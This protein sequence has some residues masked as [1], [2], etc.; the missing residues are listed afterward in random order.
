MHSI[1]KTRQ[2]LIEELEAA[3]KRIRHLEK[4]ISEPLNPDT[5]SQAWLDHSPVST[6]ALDLEFKLKYMSPS[7]ANELGIK[8]ISGYIGKKYPFD[9][10]QGSFKSIMSDALIKVKETAEIRMLEESV[11]GL[12]GKR[13]WYQ[14]TLFPVKDTKG[15]PDYYMLICLNTN[16][17]KRMEEALGKRLDLL[18]RPLDDPEV[19]KF[20]DLFNLDDIQRL[21]NEFSDATGVAS[22]ITN[23]DGRPL[24]VPSNFCRL[25]NDIIRKTEKGLKNCYKSDAVLGKLNLK[26]PIV[27]ECLSGGLWDAGAGISVGGR[28]IAN[29]L[30]GQV[31]D[32]TQTDEK[33]RAYA[34]E[35]GAAEEKVIE[36]FH[37]VP[38][39]S[40]E[41]FQKVSQV[42]F[43]LANQLSAIAYQNM[44][45]ARYIAECAL[46]E[47]K[48]KESEE[49]FRT[50]IKQSPVAIEI[51][52]PNGRLISV[53]D[54]WEKFWR[55][56]KD[57]I[58]D[59][60]ILEDPE[61]SYKGLTNA[62]S[63]ACDGKP[64]ILPDLLYNPLYSRNSEKNNRWIS[65]KMYPITDKKNLIKNIVL[66][67]DDITNRKKIEEKIKEINE[68]LERKVK[69][70]TAKLND[71]LT[72]LQFENE[73]RRKTQIK[74]EKANSAKN[75]YFS[76]LAHD[77]K[78]PLTSLLSSAELMKLYFQNGEID[79]LEQYIVKINK[80]TKNISSL[81]DDVLTWARSQSDKIAFNPEI[82]HLKELLLKNIEL[83]SIA[84]S[85]KN[86]KLQT[87]FKCSAFIIADRNMC[88]TMCSRIILSNAINLYP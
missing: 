8:N 70:R 16:Y 28:H 32:E 59:Y 83:S 13:I 30:I 2:Q 53:N 80:S 47:E 35:I 9:F 48:V 62:F 68:N 64:Q 25:C 60:N 41:K 26:G 43:T 67:Y 39:M 27:Q 31:R 63:D 72:E 77:L 12:N 51:Y 81:L 29:W 44:Q 75:R 65:A 21:Q 73:E 11:V 84:L 78:N 33:L 86:L 34:R 87:N 4:H 7:A 24:T 3:E 85:N 19:I 58:T 57:K 6:L 55:I 37:E 18:T 49:R 10:F 1:S 23:P 20:E 36:A 76:I 52:E 14:F 38:A 69:D 66:T 22:I 42:L 74:L 15:N 50:V 71:A 88:T 61:S 45:Q 40:Q 17:R 54:A 56:R 5:S 82:I 46:A 79:K